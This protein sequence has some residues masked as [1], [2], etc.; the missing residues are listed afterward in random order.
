MEIIQRSLKIRTLFKDVVNVIS[1]GL[2]MAEIDEKY[3]ESH[4]IR[5]TDEKYM[6]GI[7]IPDNKNL[8]D[9]IDN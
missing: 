3:K 4:E 1:E 2:S 7:I 5:V 9:K 6:M 8:S